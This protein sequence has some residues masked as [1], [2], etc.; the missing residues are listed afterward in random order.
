MHIDKVTK[1]TYRYVA[2]AGPGGL[3]PLVSTL[4]IRKSAFKDEAPEDIQL[5][6]T[7]PSEES[8]N[9]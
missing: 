9:A 1:N 2:Q 8:D 6:V 7:V 3:D 4:Y 5:V